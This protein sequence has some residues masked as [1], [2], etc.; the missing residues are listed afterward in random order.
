MDDARI[1]IETRK[2]KQAGQLEVTHLS[3]LSNLSRFDEKRRE[4]M[5]IM[6][7]QNDDSLYMNRKRNYG[8]GEI[9]IGKSFEL[10]ENIYSLGFMSQIRDDLMKKFLDISTGKLVERI[11]EDVVKHKHGEELIDQEPSTQLIINSDTSEQLA[12]GEIDR[13][14]YETVMRE[15]QALHK[16]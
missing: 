14:A 1:Y 6:E 12:G 7:L 9:R 13:D 16:L 5:A 10:G 15:Q 4:R 8:E 11:E 3:P 2:L